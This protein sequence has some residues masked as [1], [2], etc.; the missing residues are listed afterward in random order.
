MTK[1]GTLLCTRRILHWETKS[2]GTKTISQMKPNANATAL[3]LLHLPLLLAHHHPHPG[4]MQVLLSIFA[5]KRKKKKPAPKKCTKKS[6]FP[7]KPKNPKCFSTKIHRQA[8]S[9]PP[10]LGGRPRPER[11]TVALDALMPSDVESKDGNC[12]IQLRFFEKSVNPL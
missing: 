10:P 7:K 12:Q 2:Q 5:E 4:S 8:S 11:F 3:H 9:A 1:P 6:L